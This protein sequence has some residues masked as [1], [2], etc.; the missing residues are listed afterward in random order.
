MRIA[1]LLALA[2]LTTA[3]VFAQNGT[4]RTFVP[5]Q[6]GH[7]YRMETPRLIL[8]KDGLGLGQTTCQPATSASLKSTEAGPSR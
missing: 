1:A 7:D 2:T 8:R 4:P 6:T 3:P 5:G